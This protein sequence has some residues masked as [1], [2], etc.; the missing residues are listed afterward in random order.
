VPEF[1]ELEPCQR[2]RQPF[3]V[4]RPQE[5]RCDAPLI[6]IVLESIEQLALDPHRPHRIRRED[7]QEPVTPRQRRA[8]LVVPLLRASQ[9]TAAEENPDSVAPEDA[10]ETS[11]EGPIPIR[12]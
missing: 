4:A 2:P 8:D 3:S 10:G 9:V 7:E 5:K 12:V 11:R 6:L 1:D